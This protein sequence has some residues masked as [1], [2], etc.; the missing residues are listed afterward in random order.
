MSSTLSRDVI[1]GNIGFICS[2]TQG[3]TLDKLKINKSD[4]E[5]SS[6]FLK[7]IY[8][9]CNLHDSLLS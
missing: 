5:M 4:S 3:I 2:D 1:F 9:L 6:C 7:H 8:I